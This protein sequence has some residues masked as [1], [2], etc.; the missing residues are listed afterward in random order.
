MRQSN[1][2]SASGRKL[3]P[4][5]EKEILESAPKGTFFIILIFGLV[6]TVAWA[7]LFFGRFIANGPVN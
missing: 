7:V 2:G 5:E 4:E 1:Q 6:F 3:S